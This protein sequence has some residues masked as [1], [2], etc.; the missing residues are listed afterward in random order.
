MTKLPTKDGVGPSC[1]ALP[2][3]P[4]PQLLDFL[5]ERF[6]GVSAQDWQ[7]RLRDGQVLDEQ[8]AALT[9]DAAYAARQKIYYY[10]S[11]PAEPRVPFEELLL[12]Q[13]EHLVVADKPHFLPVTPS[14]RYLQ[15]TLLVRLKRRTGL[16]TLAPLHRIDRDTAGLVVFI[17][18]PGTRSAYHG[19]F[20][21]HA[22]HKRYEAIAPWRPD[23]RL[24]RTHRS[25]LAQ[26]AHFLQMQEVA[27]QANSETHIELME[28]QG[29]LARYA[30]QPVTGKTHQLRAHM[31]SLG[32][33]ILNDQIYPVLTPEKLEFSAEDYAQPLLLLAQSI[34]FTD[35]VTGQPREFHSQRRLHFPTGA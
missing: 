3:G 15:E 4:W 11:V 5:I 28:T 18:Q 16:D 31:N 19:L 26:S 6:P 27:G 8:G 29:R 25:R 9:P 12:F 23:L 21:Q 20:L 14:G 30:L 35:P 32:I 2:P 1:V 17:V 22:I 33:P 34:S 10:R 24:P 7:E 13:D